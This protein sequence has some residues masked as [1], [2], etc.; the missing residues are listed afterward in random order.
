LTR[1]SVEI[2]GELALARLDPKEYPKGT[3]IT[4]CIFPRLLLGLTRNG[5]LSG[6]ITSVTLT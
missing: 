4:G 1:H 3:V 2:G 6:V 5:S